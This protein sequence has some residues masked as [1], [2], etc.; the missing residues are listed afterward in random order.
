[1]EYIQSKY[2]PQGI[3]VAVVVVA[4]VVVLVVM[5]EKC[6]LYYHFK[7]I[8]LLIGGIYVFENG[9]AGK[10]TKKNPLIHDTDRL[11]Y[12]FYYLVQAHQVLNLFYKS[13][14]FYKIL[15]L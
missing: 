14:M 3:A 6:I 9:M 1:M 7:N 11:D 12:M 10:K 5:I 13:Y 2:S 4:V 15:S 8:F